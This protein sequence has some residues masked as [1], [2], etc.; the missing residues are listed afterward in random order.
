[1]PQFIQLGA[2]P[3]VLPDVGFCGAFPSTKFF[4]REGKPNLQTA[5]LSP[6]RAGLPVNAVVFPPIEQQAFA[7]GP[8]VFVQ[9]FYQ[10]LPKLAQWVPFSKELWQPAEQK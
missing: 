7:L 8:M 2:Q 9:Q 10:A 1:M 6:V 4:R 3:N 5:V